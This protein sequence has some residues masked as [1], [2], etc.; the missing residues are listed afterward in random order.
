MEKHIV[1]KV[2]KVKPCFPAVHLS[3]LQ[4]SFTVA[5]EPDR[6]AIKPQPSGSLMAFFYLLLHSHPFWLNNKY[7]KQKCV[8]SYVKE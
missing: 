6:Q 5:C 8:L 2:Q 3:A 4:L 1:F 7:Y